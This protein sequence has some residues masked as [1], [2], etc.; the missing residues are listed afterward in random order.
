MAQHLAACAPGTVQGTRPAFSTERSDDWCV[1]DGRRRRER[2]APARAGHRTAGPK[3][4]GAAAYATGLI[5]RRQ[6]RGAWGCT[7]RLPSGVG[8]LRSYRALRRCWRRRGGGRHARRQSGALANPRAAST[9]VGAH[10][11]A[12]ARGAGQWPASRV[13][14][15]GEAAARHSPSMPA[16]GHPVGDGEGRGRCVPASRPPRGVATRARRTVTACGAGRGRRADRAATP[17]A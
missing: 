11:A 8:M 15:R 13:A 3:R 10:S 9:G 5:G 7:D 16:A 14:G 1:A 6:V 12:T 17:T 2:R 4:R